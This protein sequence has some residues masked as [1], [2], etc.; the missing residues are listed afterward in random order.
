MMQSL[1]SHLHDNGQ[2]YVVM[3]DPA[4]ADKPSGALERGIEDNIFLLRSNGSVWRG[5]VW[6]GVAVFPDWFSANIS[7][8]WENEFALFFDADTGVDIDALWI[9]MNEPSNFPCDF[10]CDDPDTAAIGYPP[11]PPA[12]R[13]PPRPLPGWPCEFQPPGTDCKR[14][15]EIMDAVA[16]PSRELSRVHLIVAERQASGEQMGLPGR[17][18][19]FPKYAI[20]NK[21]AYMDSWNAGH[22]GISNHTVNTDVIHQ[23]GLAM[24]DTHSLYGSMMSMESQAA[25][26]ARRPTLR[27]MVI[28]RS[29]F[30][31]AGT[32]VGHWL[33][34]NVSSWAQYRWS[35]RTMLAFSSI[36]QVPMVGSDVRPLYFRII[37][38]KHV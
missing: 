26:L 30:P 6:P 28:T 29:T 31:G 18:L 19:L 22:G 21:A 25:M 17:D 14:S 20:H 38:W 35:I 8:Y 11:E 37:P 24:Y 1:V 27:P 3:V 32:K 12:V 4:V 13:S 5:V 15:M 33:G 7:S 36:Y 10:P 9:D 16:Y 2:K 23:N 34:D